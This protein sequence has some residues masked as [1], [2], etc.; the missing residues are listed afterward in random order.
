MLATERLER[1][2]I[3]REEFLLLKAVVIAN[4]DV[5]KMEEEAAL[6]RLREALLA[7]LHDCVA[8]IRYEF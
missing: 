7:S 1:V 5:R 8:V 6:W 2:G 3:K 4:S